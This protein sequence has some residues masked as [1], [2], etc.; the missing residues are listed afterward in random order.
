[1]LGKQHVYLLNNPDYIE[2]ALIKNYKYF[3][4]SKG[5]QVSKR[6]LGEG[7][8]TSEGEYHDRWSKITKSH[9][10]RF[11]YF[12]FGGGIR[13]CIGESFAWLEGILV[14]ATIYRN[15]KMHHNPNHKVELQPLITL[16]PKYGMMMKLEKRR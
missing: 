16:R 11:S 13:G 12:P 8:V 3:I 14:I 9:L 10:P 7:L 2:D 4:K 1:M 5:L 6:L 15:W